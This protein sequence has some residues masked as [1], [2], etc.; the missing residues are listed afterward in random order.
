PV[1]ARA[2]DRRTSETGA[3]S[4]VIETGQ[5]GE[6]RRLE[7]LTLLQPRLAPGL[8]ELVP[9]ADGEAVVAAKNAVAD[10]SAQLGRDKPLVLDGQVRDA[11]PA[12]ELVRRREG[13]G[14]ADIETAPARAA[15]VAL[16]RVRRQG[17]G[18]ED[19]AQE[20]P[21]A[22]RARDQDRVLAL[23][24]EPGGLRERLLH[25]GRG[26]DEHF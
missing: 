10:F 7:I 1:A 5:F 4:G 12:I 23:P 6:R 16:G 26:V 20:K 9:G 18:G 24:A 8:R 13:V 21:V 3:E 19:R 17:G 11:A 14:W 15:T 2:L 25:H 22:E